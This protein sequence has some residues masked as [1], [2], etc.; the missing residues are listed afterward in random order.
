M[1]DFAYFLLSSFAGSTGAVSSSMGQLG[2]DLKGGAHKAAQAV[3]LEEK[4]LSTK[5]KEDVKNVVDSA[6]VRLQS[7]QYRLCRKL[8]VLLQGGG[9]GCITRVLLASPLQIEGR[10]LGH[11]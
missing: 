5:V 9:C 6:K 3:G 8:C 11:S 10:S 2:A 7:L 4:P 1:P